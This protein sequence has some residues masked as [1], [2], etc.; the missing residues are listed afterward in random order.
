ML[1]KQ[2]FGISS[3]LLKCFLKN[4]KENR[5]KKIKNRHGYSV[6]KEV[7]NVRDLLTGVE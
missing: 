2:T 3:K 1:F 6:H 5:H 7:R 4:V